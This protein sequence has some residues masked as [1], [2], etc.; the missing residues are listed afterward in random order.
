MKKRIL[1]ALL[2]SLALVSCEKTSLFEDRVSLNNS[3]SLPQAVS[4][5]LVA[6]FGKVSVTEWKLKSN[7]T[8]MVHFMLNAVAWEASFS[9]DGTLLSSKPA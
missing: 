4:K 1:V 5:S 9:T 7:G 6:N 8:W 2:F 3:A